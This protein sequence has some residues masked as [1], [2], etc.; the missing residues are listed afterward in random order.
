MDDINTWVRGQN[1]E[2][3]EWLHEYEKLFLTRKYVKKTIQNKTGIISFLHHKLGNRKI[4]SLTP[5]ELDDFI[6]IYIANNK[7]H[8]AKQAY[9]LIRDI[10]RE[11]WLSGWIKYSPALPLRAPQVR[12]KRARLLL[13]EWQ[14]I[15][16]LSHV[17]ARPYMPHAMALALVT[18][19]RR[20][21]ISKMRRS[22]V[23][24]GYLHIEQE[25]TGQKIALPLELYSSVLDK[26]LG[27]I[28]KKC[29]GNDYLLSKQRRVMPWSLSYGFQISRDAAFPDA[30]EL[31]RDAL[32]PTFHEQR[33]LAERIFRDENIDT[34]LLLGHRSMQMT[35]KYH[36]NR[37]RDWNYLIIK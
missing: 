28:I 31:W 32:P 19:Q 29:P 36:D 7:H 5:R 1:R 33:S 12:V 10:F 9:I 2:L 21:D 23:F 22:D 15:Y 13:P 25:K 8:A 17:I 37:G 30:N 6:N 35:D 3:T 11:A 34:Q 16:K 4:R 20:G 14:K 26:T 27:D 24:N 18:G